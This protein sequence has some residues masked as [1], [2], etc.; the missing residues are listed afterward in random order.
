MEILD[1]IWSFNTEHIN[2]KVVALPEY[3]SDLSWDDSGEVQDKINSGEY[4]EFTACAI[5]TCTTTGEE[6]AS[7]YL[8]SCIYENFVDFRDN[9]GMNQRG[10]GSYF[11]D[12]VKTV[13]SEA[14]RTIL[15]RQHIYSTLVVNH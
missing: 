14:R 11:S 1:T 6:L 9:V 12:M 7:D 2:V 13:C 15:D 10:H 5:V 3:C 8:G 4:V